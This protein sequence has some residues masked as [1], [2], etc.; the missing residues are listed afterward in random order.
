MGVAGRGVLPLSQGGK[1]HDETLRFPATDAVIIPRAILFSSVQSLMEGHTMS[2]NENV[3]ELIERLGRNAKEYAIAGDCASAE[4]L[5]ACANTIKDQRA[6]IEYEQD[7]YE[8][9]MHLVRVYQDKL[10]PKYE[11]LV[12]KLKQE[13]DALI[14]DLRGCA[15]ESCAECMYCLYRTAPSFCSDCTDG[16]NWRWKGAKET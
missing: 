6:R 10:V 5:T 1:L 4:F 9:S 14:S 7:C 2:E 12:E 13:H 8:R 15:I 16:S 11:A 3:D